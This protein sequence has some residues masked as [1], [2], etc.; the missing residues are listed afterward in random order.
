M[1]NLD[2]IKAAYFKGHDKETIIERDE[3]VKN[4]KHREK[5][6][7]FWLKIFPKDSDNLSNFI[8]DFSFL[9]YFIR[10]FLIIAINLNL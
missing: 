5:V 4:S 1:K 2:D 8:M 10:N 6:I 7:A 9:K 3:F